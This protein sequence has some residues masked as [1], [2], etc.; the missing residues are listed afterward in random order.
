MVDVEE[1]GLVVRPESACWLSGSATAFTVWSCSQ[2]VFSRVPLRPRGRSCRPAAEEALA[3]GHRR[4]AL[5]ML[6]CPARC[7]RALAGG[8]TPWR[9]CQRAAVMCCTSLVAH[10]PHRVGALEGV[11]DPRRGTADLLVASPAKADHKHT[12]GQCRDAEHHAV[13]R[14]GALESAVERPQLRGPVVRTLHAPPGSIVRV[15]VECVR[16]DDSTRRRATP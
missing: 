15:D 5:T 16:L 9:A 4:R 14:E 1:R 12:V 2:K 8:S 6:V 3:V 13:H 10:R 7:S 11:D